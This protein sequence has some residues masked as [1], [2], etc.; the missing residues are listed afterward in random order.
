M[1][2]ICYL[3]SSL[4]KLHP[5]CMTALMKVSGQPAL[6]PTANKL[7]GQLFQQG[8]KKS[9]EV[10]GGVAPNQRGD[11]VHAPCKQDSTR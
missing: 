1:F 7:M 5:A 10:N 9:G 4:S 2:I 3:K 6:W 8:R 11:V